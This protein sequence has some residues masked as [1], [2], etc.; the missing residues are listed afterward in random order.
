[1][2]ALRQ[3]C[4]SFLHDS[5]RRE[6]PLPEEGGIGD[7]GRHKR[8][9]RLDRADSMAE[10]A[11]RPE[12]SR[13]GPQATAEPREWPLFTTPCLTRLRVTGFNSREGQTV[14]VNTG[15]ASFGASMHANYPMTTYLLLRGF[16]I[17]WWLPQWRA[18]TGQWRGPMMS[19]H[20][21]IRR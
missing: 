8:T 9:K 18:A 15:H 4:G 12:G 2:H 5:I 21:C 11:P 19:L 17:T 1:M 20:S 3:N 16:S 6:W 14:S 7:R 10:S 13:D